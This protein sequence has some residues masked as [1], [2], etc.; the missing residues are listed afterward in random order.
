[1]HWLRNAWDI[2]NNIYGMILFLFLWLGRLIYKQEKN[3]KKDITNIIS[4]PVWWDLEALQGMSYLCFVLYLKL[5]E[6]VLF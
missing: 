2:K 1:M 4:G 3:L 6:L 5:G